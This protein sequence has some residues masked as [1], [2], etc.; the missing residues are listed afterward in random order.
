MS[1]N[2]SLLIKIDKE[3]KKKFI[4]MCKDKDTNASREV[5]HF[6]KNYIEKHK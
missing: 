2:D 6:I 3:D 1:K 4:K 5:R